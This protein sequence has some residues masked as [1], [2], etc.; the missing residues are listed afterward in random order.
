M[1][2]CIFVATN[3]YINFS[4]KAKLYNSVEKRVSTEYSC[5]VKLSVQQVKY[6]AGAR[7]LVLMQW[8]SCKLIIVI[9]FAFALCGPG[10]V[11][12]SLGLL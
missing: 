8:G 2:K 3:K 12:V 4:G 9:Q 6:F 5:T 7:L 1:K 10:L 11:V